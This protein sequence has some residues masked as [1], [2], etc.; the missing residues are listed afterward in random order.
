MNGEIAHMS[1]I[2]MSARKAL[3][4][5]DEIDF[6]PDKYVLSVKFVFAP[7]RSMKKSVES[8]SVCKWFDICKEM[9]MDDIK[10]IVP[11]A[12]K[13]R[14]ILGFSNSSQGSIVCFWGKSKVTYFTPAW[15]FDKE[16]H[17]WNVVYEE[18]VWKE[19]PEGKPSFANRSEEFKKALLDI[20][21][22]ATD[23]EFKNFAD[24]FHK[25]Y[26][27][28]C[29]YSYIEDDNMPVHIP[30]EF[31]GI[32]YAIMHA[33]VFGA[34]GSWNDSPPYYAE[35]KGLGKEYDELSNK[36]LA[37]LRY[38]LMYVVNECWKRN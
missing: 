5:N 25:A 27:A 31:R 15:E 34:M 19:A 33:D 24:I 30:N 2:V 37:Q 3:Y 14:N 21:K 26:E 22:L 17:G 18:H 12:V 36:L 29:D 13:D 11:M 9:N 23:I 16:N 1:G 20:E 28:L 32:Y 35:E 7:R 4:D 6:V 8:D 10:F 38:N